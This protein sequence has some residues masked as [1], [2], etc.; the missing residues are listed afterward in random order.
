MVRG[1]FE[2]GESVQINPNCRIRSLFEIYGDA[3]GIINRVETYNTLP[4]DYIVRFDVDDV[5]RREVSLDEG[6]LIPAKTVPEEDIAITS[7]EKLF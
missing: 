3:V 2:V 5:T 6:F 1:I 7:I 4:P